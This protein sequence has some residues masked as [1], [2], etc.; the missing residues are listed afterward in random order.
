[1]CTWSGVIQTIGLTTRLALFRPLL[2]RLSQPTISFVKL[3]DLKEKLPATNDL[4]ICLIP[5]REIYK[6]GAWDMSE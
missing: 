1:M 6:R 4:E 5:L 2:R 3:F